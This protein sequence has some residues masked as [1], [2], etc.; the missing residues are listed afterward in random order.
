[1]GKRLL[2]LDD[3]YNYYSTY[4]R[5]TH[6][7]CDEGNKDPIVVQV[8]GTL[9]FEQ[10]ENNEGLMPVRLQACHTNE[11][12]NK[13]SIAYEVMEKMLPSFANRPILGFIHEVNGEYYFAGHEMHE[14]GD[15]LVYD[16]V[17]VGIIPETNNIHMEY[18][19]EKDRYNVIVDGWIFE[20]YSKAAEILE[21]EEELSVS[22]ELSLRDVSY[23]A[24][25]RNLVINDAYFTGVTILGVD[26]FGEEVKPGMENSNITIKDF[27]RNSLFSSIDEEQTTKLIDTLEKLN[28][29]LSK[30]NINDTSEKGGNQEM[31]KF[32]ELLQKYNKTIEDVTFEYE[33]LNDEELEQAF[34]EAFGEIVTEDDQTI[35]SDPVENEGLEP[36]AETFEDGENDNDE[37]ANDNP[38]NS[39]ESNE[40]YTRQFSISQEDTRHGLYVLLAQYEEADNEWYDI[41]A[42]Y[43]SYFV[44]TG[45]FGNKTYKQNYTV[46]EDGTVSFEGERIELI[47]EYLTVEEKAELD[48][49][50]N[51]Y[52][53]IETELNGYKTAELNSKKAEIMSNDNYADFL[54]CEEFENIKNNIDS[55]DLEQLQV[56]C[57]LAFAKCV[58]KKGQFSFNPERN[59]GK[60]STV[61]IFGDMNQSS[62]KSSFLDGLLA[63]SKK[64]NN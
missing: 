32:E 6:Y 30:F 41:V 44:F 52:S 55:Y 24:K 26:D 10:N 43:D 22:V 1:M 16:E 56:Q 15:E 20:N 21:R 37:P 64:N 39:S 4:Q 60:T 3:L 59:E 17:P 38:D 5:S 12:L 40:V 7:S 18:D 63:L 51:N 53:S 42:T 58:Q 46:S 34:E 19:E 25:D 48:S 35:D 27:T 29:T 54:E 9:K 28:F 8:G 31:N 45:I 23:S 50:R 14:E 33:N 57:D 62:N 2:T 11:N 49:M 47:C 36:E 13:S 61:S